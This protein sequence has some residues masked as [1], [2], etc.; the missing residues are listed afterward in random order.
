MSA[1]LGAALVMSL[2]TTAWAQQPGEAAPPP[3]PMPALLRPKVPIPAELRDRLV[4]V[5]TTGDSVEGKLLVINDDEIIVETY[6]R[7][8]MTIERA[9][10]VE[11]RLRYPNAVPAVASQHRASAVPAEPPST[12]SAWGFWGGLSAGPVWGRVSRPARPA[13]NFGLDL[14]VS[15]HFVYVGAGGNVTWFRGAGS[16]SNDTTGGVMDSGAPVAGAAYV[17]AGFTKGLFIPYNATEAIELRPGV[18]YGLMAMSA[19]NQ[20]ISNCVDCDSRSFDYGGGHYVRFQL[21]VFYSLHPAGSVRYRVF[22]SRN[23]LFMG[24]IVSFQEFVYGSGPRPERILS[25]GY[26]VGWG[27]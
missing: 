11:A 7:L 3:P 4:V 18:G 17:E 6:T 2:V 19:A 22:M 16:F 5:T 13:G 27:P 26:S 24:G 1:A 12:P 25:L 8:Q 23:G 20:S 21:G 15:F 10:I 14:A 9:K